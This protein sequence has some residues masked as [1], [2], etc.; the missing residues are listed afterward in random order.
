MQRNM[1][2]E[3]CIWQRNCRSL[4][5]RRS[6]LRPGPVEVLGT[7]H[8]PLLGAV[9]ASDGRLGVALVAES[10]ERLELTVESICDFPISNPIDSPCDC[11]A[12]RA[13]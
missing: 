1:K 9:G 10:P 3:Y 8:R 6:L 4:P 13:V 12:L 5:H 2:K 11:D 7:A